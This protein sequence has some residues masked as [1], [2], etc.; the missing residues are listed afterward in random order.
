[1]WR[2]GAGSCK[3]VHGGGDFPKALRSMVRTWEPSTACSL[4]PMNVLKEA[5]FDRPSDA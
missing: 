5:S 3:P 2:G 1:M 4:R